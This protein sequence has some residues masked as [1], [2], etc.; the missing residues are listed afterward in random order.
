MCENHGK[1][2]WVCLHSHSEYSILDGYARISDYIDTAKERGAAGFGLTDHGTMAG[3][4]EMIQKSNEA[5]IQPVPGFEAYVAPENPDGAFHKSPVY[6]GPNGMKAPKYDVSGNG[7]YLHLTLWAYNKTGLHNL[8]KLT[9]LAW[10]QERYYL[11]P[12]IDTDLLFKYSE[13]LIVTTGCPSSEISTRFLLGQ[14]D[15]AYE[16][17]SRLKEVFGEHMFV[18]VMDHNMENED[19]ERILLPKLRK[20]SEDL[21]IP[22]LATNDC[23]YV[24]KDDADAHERM[25]AM[26][27]QRKMNE[28]SFNEGG[29]RFAFSGPEYYMKSDAEM[30]AL[31]PEDL[32]PG[33]VDN[34]NVVVDMC[35]EFTLDYDPNLRPEIELPEGYTPVTYLQKLIKEGFAE[36]RG[37]SPREIQL[38]SKRRIKEEFEV[39]H[40]NDFVSYF[41][42]VHD[43]IDWAHKNGVPTGT[44]RGCFLPGSKVKLAN[45]KEVVIEDTQ[46]GELV[47]IVDGEKAEVTDKFK[48]EV[49]DESIS[50]ITLENGEVI[51]STDDH[52]FLTINNGYVRAD[53][54]KEGALLLA[55]NDDNELTKANHKLLNPESLVTYP[56]AAD[57]YPEGVHAKIVFESQGMHRLTSFI[58]ATGADYSIGEVAFDKK[59]LGTEKDLIT[60]MLV[61]RD[62]NDETDVSE[63][64]IIVVPDNLLGANEIL[65]I[66]TPEMPVLIMPEK[67]TEVFYYGEEL[68][69]KP[70][71]VVS[72]EHE[73]YTGPVY[74][75]EIDGFYNYTINGVSVHNSVGGS[76]IAYVLDISDTDPIRFDLLFE[77]FLSPGRGS[78]YRIEYEDGTYE[79]ISVSEKRKVRRADGSVTEVYIHELHDGDV[80]IA[81]E[82]EDE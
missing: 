44:G 28:P 47:A 14:D 51:K 39:I 17:A 48:Y 8:F 15:K 4:Y 22:M 43:Y 12:R 38:E 27:T 54:L 13:G 55:S 78:L 77:R 9:S 31:F 82:E 80:L 69:N 2:E 21:D 35:S 37:D 67:A 64:G 45:G 74:D 72:V 29:T 26:Q 32:Y 52:L 19:L 81:D 7:A 1:K 61:I 60:S 73:L 68:N 33:A 49:T 53:E 75:L 16:Y 20:L 34:T 23:H 24:Y 59:D 79:D 63:Y 46:V 50:I 65:T 10:E 11:K 71:R 25:L 18:E 76:E 70:V 42:V 3:I 30:R 40:S 62:E 66:D 56:Y 5:G 58:E 36:K 41:L 57:I 6:Y